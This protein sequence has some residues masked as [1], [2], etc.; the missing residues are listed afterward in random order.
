MRTWGL[1]PLHSD[2]ILLLA[3]TLEPAKRLGFEAEAKSRLGGIV[4]VYSQRAGITLASAGAAG[5]AGGSS[6]GTV[7]NSEEFLKFQADQNQFASQQIEVYM[8]YL[9]CDSC[10]G[11]LAFDKKSNSLALQAKLDSIIPRWHSTSV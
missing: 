8:H 9:G 1:G 6:G 7:I 4:S 3:T 10:A 5:G 11:E 2:A